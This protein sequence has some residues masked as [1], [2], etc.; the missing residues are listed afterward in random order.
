M[1]YT[2]LMSLLFGF[3]LPP[4]SPLSGWPNSG[5]L[6]FHLPPTTRFYVAGVAFALEHMHDRRIVYRD[7]KPERLG[8]KTVMPVPL[9]R[10]VRLVEGPFCSWPC[11]FHT[12]GNSPPVPCFMSLCA[13]E[14]FAGPQWLRKVVSHTAVFVVSWSALIYLLRF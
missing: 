8:S 5:Q 11:H 13:E 1:H 2:C 4:F 6:P 3:G 10:L 14:H 7:V 9:W 12:V